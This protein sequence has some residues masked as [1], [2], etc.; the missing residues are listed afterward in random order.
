MFKTHETSIGPVFRFFLGALGVIA[1]VTGLSLAIRE[2]W[3][4]FLGEWLRLVFAALFLVIMIGGITLLRGA[5]RGR[6]AVR[7]YR[8]KRK[9]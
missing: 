5:I 4:A 1:I 3:L 2:T 8:T 6:L 9:K 7:S